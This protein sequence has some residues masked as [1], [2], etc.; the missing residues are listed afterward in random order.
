MV[1]NEWERRRVQTL[2]PLPASEEGNSKLL[3]AIVDT[4]EYKTW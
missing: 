4:G 1:R 2:L 3:R